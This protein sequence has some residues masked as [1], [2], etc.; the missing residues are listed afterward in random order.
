MSGG[1][2]K[3]TTNTHWLKKKPEVGKG[4][5]HNGGGPPEKQGARKKT[6]KRIGTGGAKSGVKEAWG[7]HTPMVIIIPMGAWLGGRRPGSGR[8][9]VGVRDC[10]GGGVTTPGQ[11]SRKKKGEFLHVSGKRAARTVGCHDTQGPIKGSP[12]CGVTKKKNKNDRGLGC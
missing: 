7:K 9:E 5:Q 11:F 6:C 12:T 3:K 10:W 2:Q 1:K 4:Q 8:T